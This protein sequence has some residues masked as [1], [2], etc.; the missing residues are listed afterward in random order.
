MKVFGYQE[1]NDRLL[2]LE[3]VSIKCTIN[4][5]QK[6][7]G[8]LNKVQ[9]EHINVMNKTDMCHSHFRDYD[10]E[11]KAGEPDFIIVTVSD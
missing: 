1:N 3:E 4:E 5:L 6:I 11:W 10:T 9:N 8:F 7:I 2:N